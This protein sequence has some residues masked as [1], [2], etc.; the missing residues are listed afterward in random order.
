MSRHR[1]GGRGGTSEEKRR[2][3]GVEK[4]NGKEKQKE[5]KKEKEKEKES[6]AEARWWDAQEASSGLVDLSW[7]VRSRGLGELGLVGGR[8]AKVKRRSQR[9]IQRELGKYR[10]RKK[11]KKKKKQ[12]NRRVCCRRKGVVVLGVCVGGG[13]IMFQN[14]GSAQGRVR[15]VVSV[16]GRAR[17]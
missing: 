6:E 10:R 13:V 3:L 2:R 11:K 1:S 12:E 8:A 16:R 7:M 4:E 9:I 5:K 15:W 14:N 17:S